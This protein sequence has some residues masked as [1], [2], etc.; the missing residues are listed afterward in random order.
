MSVVATERKIEIK[1]EEK[2]LSV[3]EKISYG[4]G[5][6]GNGFMFD[7]GQLYLLKFFTDVAG[8]PAA[9]AG[10]IFLV[11]KL[12]AAVCDP[13]VGSSIDYRKNIGAKGK[14]RPYLLF[15][16]MVLAILTVLTFIS[17]NLSPADRK[18]VV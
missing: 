7:L 4:M 18:S 10:G 2:N 5:D 15:G 8:I 16:S 14:F 3:K 11:S 6:F 17:P 12:F 1:V 9:A 13:I